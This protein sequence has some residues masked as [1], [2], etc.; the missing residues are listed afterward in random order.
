MSC[1]VYTTSVITKHLAGCK[2][3]TQLMLLICY[4]TCHDMYK[5]AKQAL[6]HS[7]RK[8]QIL[9]EQWFR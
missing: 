5:Q 4:I 9:D 6:C 1:H 2:V 7:A 3:V 8:P